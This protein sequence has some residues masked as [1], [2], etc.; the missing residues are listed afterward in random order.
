[1]KVF[2]DYTFRWWQV[3]LLKIALLSLGILVGT[4]FS[5]FFAGNQGLLALLWCLFLIPTIYLVAVLP[6]L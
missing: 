1:M 5:S 2:H 3:G 4:D 6:K